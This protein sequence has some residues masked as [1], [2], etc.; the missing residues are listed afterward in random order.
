MTKKNKKAKK[1]KPQQQD[2][3]EPT[4][5]RKKKLQ[6]AEDKSKPAERGAAFT[7]KIQSVKVMDDG[8]EASRFQFRL[9]GK[10]GEHRTYCVD[11]ADMVRFTALVALLTGAMTSGARVNVVAASGEQEPRIATAIDIRPKSGT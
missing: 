8:P 7:G 11:P 1:P 6:G 5:K 2:I 9:D 3:A 10:G 4:K